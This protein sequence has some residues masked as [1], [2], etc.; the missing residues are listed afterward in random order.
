MFPNY[1][2]HCHHFHVT[3]DV[4]RRTLFLGPE[5][6]GSNPGLYLLEVTLDKPCN[7]FKYFS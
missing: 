1:L 2:R 6:L 5:A 3:E 4:M 7:F